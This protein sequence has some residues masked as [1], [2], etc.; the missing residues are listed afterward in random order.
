MFHVSRYND[1]YLD[2][3]CSTHHLERLQRIQVLDDSST[4]PTGPSLLVVCSAQ[5][6]VSPLSK[7]LVCIAFPGIKSNGQKTTLWGTGTPGRKK[8][9]TAKAPQK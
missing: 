4:R 5:M 6:D 7:G 2:S 9:T 1:S 3:D 8:K